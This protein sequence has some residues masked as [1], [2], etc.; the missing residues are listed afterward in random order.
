MLLIQQG[1]LKAKKGEIDEKNIGM[2]IAAENSVY[3]FNRNGCFRRNAYY[4]QKHRY[5]DRL[6]MILIALSSMKLALESYFVYEPEDSQIKIISSELDF[7]F[8]YAFIFEC[9]LKTIALGFTMDEGSYLRDSWNGLDFF[10]VSTSIIDMLLA[11]T[12]IPALKVLRLLRMIRPLRVISHNPQ[13][14]MIVAALFESVGSIINVSV[15]VLIIWMMFAIYGMNTY[16]GMFFYCSKEPY[17]LNTR[18]VCQDAGGEWLRFDSNFD[19]I[20]QAMVTLFIVSSLEGWP[21]IMHQA[22]DITKR[23]NGPVKENSPG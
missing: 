13:L 9:I 15:V 2:D 19:N 17:K 11:S 5:F 10:I 3:L 18:W 20:G 14:K 4:L 21:D 22:I 8:N 7:V 16:M 23:D 12:D 1:I 6:I